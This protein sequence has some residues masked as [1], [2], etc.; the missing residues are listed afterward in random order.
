MNLLKML[1]DRFAPEPETNVIPFPPEKD[2]VQGDKT[3]AYV[4]WL[5]QYHPEQYQQKFENWKHK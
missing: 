2:P 5:K 4:E 3:P 1:R